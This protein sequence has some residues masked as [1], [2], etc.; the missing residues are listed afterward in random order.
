MKKKRIIKN[1]RQTVVSN[2]MYGVVRI[3]FVTYTNLLKLICC[4]KR[5]ELRVY[6]LL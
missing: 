4:V 5:T 1:T 3:L 6:V 2:V